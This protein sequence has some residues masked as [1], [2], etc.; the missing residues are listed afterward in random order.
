MRCRCCNSVEANWISY[1]DEY[2]CDECL[3]VIEDTVQE[4]FEDVLEDYIP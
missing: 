3:E 2:Y 1:Y 4:D